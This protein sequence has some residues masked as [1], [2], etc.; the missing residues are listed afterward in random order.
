M[1]LAVAVALVLLA[2]PA[3]AQQQ[4]PMEQALAQ[5]LGIEVNASLQCSAAQIT[6]QAELA[7]AQARV[8]E[9]EAKYEPKAEPA[10]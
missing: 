5:K 6:T 3:L 9:L 7:K 4:S 8:R 1:K 2:V 10:K